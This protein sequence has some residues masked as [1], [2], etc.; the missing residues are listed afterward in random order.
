MIK[1]CILTSAHSPYD[2]RIYYREAVSLS[3]SGYKVIIIAPWEHSELTPDGIEIVAI[4]K[5]TTRVERF[6]L[7]TVRIFKNAILQRAD[8]YHFHD[9]DLL[10][11]MILFSALGKRVVYDIHEYNGKSILTKTWIPS[12]LRQPLAM[13]VEW[14]EKRAGNYCSGIITVN[15]HMARLFGKYNTGVV[16][17]A[18]Y[19]L[20][21]FLE[22]CDK[23]RK[24]EIKRIIYVGG[25][26]K[27]RGYEV[28]LDTME[29]IRRRRSD[30]E[31]LIVGPID[32]K[33]VNVKYPKLQRN[34]KLING[35]RWEGV[36]N[37]DSIPDYLLSACVGWIP[38]QWTP[39]NDQGTPVKSFEYMAAGLPVVASKLGF[40]G[41]IVDETNCGLLV[42]PSD[43]IA[44]ADAI[45]YLLDHPDSA[46]QMGERG[47]RAV[48]QRYNWLQEEEKLLHL[49]KDISQTVSEF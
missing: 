24:R 6:I 2:D 15:D 10:P 1:V 11:W 48:T 23:R 9:P 44:H 49:Y 18:N 5:P 32:D 16:S 45:C 20:P 40:I 42:P 3:R 37:F 26:N 14:A 7:T 22:K 46:I 25:L 21:W 47:K 33:D 31:C 41:R 8:I 4:K 39:N 36:V 35:I 30:I 34:D 27:Q 38:W 13:I 29:I 19:P 43:P 28:I 17:V 12:A